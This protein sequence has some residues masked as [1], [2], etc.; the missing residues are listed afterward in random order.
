MTQ[1]YITIDTEYSAGVV[2]RGGRDTRTEAFARSIACAS[3]KGDVGIFYQMDVFER[4][5]LKGVFFVDPMPAL[6]W[7]VEAI[8]DVVGPIVAR[9]HDVQLHCHTEWLQWAREASPVGQK[10]GSNLFDFTLDE[11]RAI[12]GYARDVLVQ[13]GAPSPV[14]FRAGNYGANDDTLR[15]LAA[16]GLEYDTSHCPALSPGGSKISLH[17]HHRSPMQHCGVI[18]VPVGCIRSFGDKLRH[19]QITALSAW[20]M[21]AAL[22]HARE[23]SI[24]SF[25]LVSH[26]FELFGRERGR[27]NALLVNRFEKLCQGIA[28]MEGV[29]T[30]TYSKNPPQVSEMRACRPVLPHSEVRTAL[31]MAEQAVGNLF[32][33]TG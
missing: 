10:T 3:P 23:R 32:Y 15:A 1:V 33:G 18:E 25:T 2:A 5:G 7:G 13:A 28:A 21:L 30:A 17:A 8:A 31:R 26:S 19:A 9:G 22:E 12:L 11:Q 20:E 29:T 6:I 4:H 24:T 27:P 14:A 16:L